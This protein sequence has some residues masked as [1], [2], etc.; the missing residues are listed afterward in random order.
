MAKK[1]ELLERLQQMYDKGK[2]N[3]R[4]FIQLASAA[5]LVSLLPSSLKADQTI[6]NSPYQTE[7]E[8]KINQTTI[9]MYNRAKELGIETVW[10]RYSQVTTPK[11]AGATCLMCQQGPCFKVKT[12]G[13]CGASKDVIVCKN[14]LGET[15]RGAAAHVGHARRI[16]KI[17]KGIGDGSITNYQ[18]KHPKK[19]ET[20]AQGLGCS[21]N[22]KQ[23]AETIQND[24][25]SLDGTP[26][27]LQAKALPE[28]QQKWQEKGIILKN[29]GCPEIM[30]AENSLAMGMD[31]DVENML[32][33]ACRLGLVDA[34][35]G[36]YVATQIQDILLGVPEIQYIK[37]NLSVIDKNKINIVVHGHIPAIAESMVA[38]VEMYNKDW[39]GF[40]NTPEINLVGMCCTGM[41]VL[42]RHGLSYAG[43]ILQQELAIATGAVE[44][45][46]VDIQCTQPAVVEA[47]K[48][49]GLHTKIITT[50]PEAKIEGP[51][52]IVEHKEFDPKKANEFAQDLVRI[53]KDNYKQN[54]DKYKVFVPNIE[55]T[56]M[57]AGFS[58]ETLAKVL[59]NV[60]PGD[61]CGALVGQ[62]QNGNIR[63]VVAVI[64]CVTPRELYYGYRTVELIKELIK[65]DVLVVLT[66]CVATIASYHGL[67]KLP[68]YDFSDYPEV[69]PGLKAVMRTIADKNRS[70][71][72]DGK[73]VPP[74]IF[75][76][77]C[78]DNSRIEEVLNAL[79]NYLGVR[80]DQLPAAGSSPEYIAEK[81]VPIGF[82][83][84]DLGLFTHLGDPPNVLAS[85]RVVQWLTQDVEKIFGG[86]FYVQS[87]PYKSAQKLMEVVEKKRANLGLDS[88]SSLFG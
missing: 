73:A 48:A 58:T 8:F 46:V 7:R 23:V 24:L 55:P 14:L 33:R 51:E 75:M 65:N 57:L 66:G 41:E 70:T 2:I 64:G 54:R 60:K 56:E 35:C 4:Q 52:E 68:E 17:L 18:I 62:I 85:D 22:A 72:P 59:D 15:A 28:R 12:K 74:C 82:W 50:D 19:L 13:V 47:V 11:D 84:V 6:P 83:A 63:G 87:D 5:G 61:P 29:G 86:K 20:L 25:S 10:D 49:S 44:L 27:M 76:G 88:R 80:I 16:A 77:A 71:V 40:Y 32:K 1:S 26:K 45:M 78:V 43:D 21:N 37:T 38:A 67:M 3:R 34:Y 79:A 36:M 69:G 30:E 81:A 9:D 42:M 53:A 31:A 39:H